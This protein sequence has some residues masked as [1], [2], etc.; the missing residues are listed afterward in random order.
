L[1]AL[2]GS[3]IRSDNLDAIGTLNVSV[4]AT[5]YDIIPVALILDDLLDDLL[6]NPKDEVDWLH[7]E[8]SFLKLRK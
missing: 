7:T 8:S 5:L 3:R 4:R 1:T 6:D 2:A